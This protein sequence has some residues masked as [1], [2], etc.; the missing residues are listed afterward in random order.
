MPATQPIYPKVDSNYHSAAGDAGAI[1][2]LRSRLSSVR[3]VAYAPA[4]AI[5]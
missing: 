1:E 4:I 2:T 3:P 5:E